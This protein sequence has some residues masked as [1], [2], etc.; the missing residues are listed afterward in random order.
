MDIVV[1]DNIL[2][3]L[4]EYNNNLTQN[5]GNTIVG[6]APTSPTYPLT[7]FDEIRNQA[8]AAYNTPYDKVSSIGYRVDIFAKTKGNV[9]KQ[10]IARKIAK[11]IDNYLTN[12]VGLLQVSWNLN[13][14]ENDSSIYHLTLTYSASLHENRRRII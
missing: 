10:T 12:Y 13:E 4:K 7:V 9:T 5:Y 6:I 11:D 8:N 2:N 1:Y 14:L 3:G